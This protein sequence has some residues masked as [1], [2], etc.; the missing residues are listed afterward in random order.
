MDERKRES[1]IAYLRRRMAQ[2]GIKVGDLAAAIAE[3]RARPKSTRYRNASGETWDGKGDMPQWLKQST[4]AGQSL[5]H[6]AV[7]KASTSASRGGAPHAKRGRDSGAKTLLRCSEAS[8]MA[9]ELGLPRAVRGARRLRTGCVGDDGFMQTFDWKAVCARCL[10]KQFKQNVPVARLPRSS[11]ELF[12][13]G[14]L[15]VVEV[16]VK[17]RAVRPK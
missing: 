15:F 11:C 6:F 9:P 12:E 10:I 1:M 7:D 13:Q 2:V 5:A 3:D 8:V 17:Q 4:S 14:S 16:S